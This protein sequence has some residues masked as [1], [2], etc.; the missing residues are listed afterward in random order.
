M[1]IPLFDLSAQQQ[2]LSQG[3]KLRL[4]NVLSH[5]Q[6]I[7]GPEVVEL[8]KRLAGMT[9]VKHCITCGNGTDALLISLLALG[10]KPGDEVIT[11]AFSYIAAA[12][13][14]ALIGAEPVFVDV[15][16]VTFNLDPNLLSDLITDKTK[17]IVPVSLYGR[18]SDFD[19]INN[20]AK[21][22]GLFVL[23]DAA[24][25]FGATYKNKKSCN[26]SLLATTSFFPTKPLGCYG[27]GGAI[28]TNDDDI[29][30]LVKQIRNH[31]QE[32]KYLHKRIGLNSRLDTMQA[33]ILL[34]KLQTFNEE[35]KLR[36]RIAAYYNE[37]LAG[38]TSVITPEIDKLD[39]S[40]WA[41]YTLKVR[42]RDEW[43]KCL[44]QKG[45]ATGVY[46]KK[47]V[48]EQ[49]SINKKTHH[50]ENSQY[51]V[52]SVLSIPMHPYLNSSDLKYICE[53]IKEID[54]KI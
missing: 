8:E 43:I 38:L 11:P 22:H 31:G 12:E 4:N 29:A 30:Q 27:D 14:I 32:E 45:I 9:K 37:H 34:E 35:I 16:P 26:L 20:L 5:G 51:L 41:L 33:A 46:Y 7:L 6:Y 23:E 50:L 39:K 2:V 15:D 25:S 52:N 36:R 3:L 44:E 49:A 42:N 24:Q 47:L 28:F 17:A 1:I 13:A 53:S 48:N 18:C 40:A 54:A 19:T 10:I 21:Q